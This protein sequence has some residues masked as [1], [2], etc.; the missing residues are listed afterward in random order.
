MVDYATDKAYDAD[1]NFKYNTPKKFVSVF[2]NE[3]DGRFY[4]LCA[5]RKVFRFDAETGSLDNSGKWGSGIDV[6][7]FGLY[8]TTSAPVFVGDH[9]YIVS[10]RTTSDYR[11]LTEIT[12]STG[13]TSTIEL[14]GEAGRLERITCS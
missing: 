10:A 8:G 11:G 12:L 3:D 14:K 2:Y 1:L 4:G 6:T 7:W 9:M 5:D 13:D